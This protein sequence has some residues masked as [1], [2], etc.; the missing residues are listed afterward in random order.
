V[1]RPDSQLRVSVI[2]QQMARDSLSFVRFAD[3]PT[4][5][6]RNPLAIL[7]VDYYDMIMHLSTE[8]DSSDL[9]E[10]STFYFSCLT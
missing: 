9:E 4:H 2:N 5:V 3:R 1:L 6:S 10:R 8:I 7:S